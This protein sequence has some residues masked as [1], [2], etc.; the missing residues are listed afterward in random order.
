MRRLSLAL[1][2]ALQVPALSAEEAGFEA[3]LAD[4]QAQ[5]RS[6]GLAPWIVDEL[7]PSLE[8]QPRVI[9]L[10]R[11]QPEFVQTFE[12]YF[13]ARVTQ[14]RVARGRELYE[15]HHD[16]LD[17]LTRQYGIPGHYLV[18]FWGLETNFGGYLGNTPTLDSL[19]T[20]ACDQRRS[21]FFTSELMTA[22]GLVERDGLDPATMRGS[23]AGAMGHT[24]FMPSTYRRAAVDGDGDG[25]IDLWGSP[26]D[27]LASGARFLQ[28]LGWERGLRWGREVRLPADFTYADAG[29][30][31][32]R[33][34]AEWAQAGV[35]R[36]DGRRLPAVALKGAIL[37]P[38][39]HEGPAFL[40]YQ[41][42]HVIMGW[43][44]SEFYALAVGHLA[45]R[46]A[47]A[48]KLYNPPPRQTALTR[49]DVSA[50]QR[51]LAAAGHDPGGSDGILGPATRR[52]LRGFQSDAGLI[53]DGY[54]DAD[55]LAAL[56]SRT[57]P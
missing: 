16:F 17:A 45:D 53:A 15:K 46:I 40:V 8:Q 50:M 12:R 24:Q 47:G 2:F 37:V 31:N 56:S 35:L 41:N 27:A 5:A 18:A 55:T 30:E 3:C 14:Q 32:A 9:E 29:L 39:G 42:F 43:N 21:K 11:Q 10:D 49:D 52:A 20:L 33:P 54:P 36:A 26:R 6:R 19:A 4:L 57:T 7:I 38:A 51:A 1:L 44:R 13:N 22:L 23:W 28:Q 25:R 48:G 34:L